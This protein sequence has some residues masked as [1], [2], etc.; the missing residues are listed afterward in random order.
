MVD[1]SEDAPGTCPACGAAYASVSVHADPVMVN[2]L[3]N[4]RYCRVCFDPDIDDGEGR[5]YFY[6]HTHEQV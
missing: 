1:I 5:L 2:L 6:H 3:D 4:E